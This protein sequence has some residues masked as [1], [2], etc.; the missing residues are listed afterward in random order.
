MQLSFIACFFLLF[1]LYLLLFT[2]YFLLFTFYFLLFTLYFLYAK[3]FRLV[4][5]DGGDRIKVNASIGT[6]C[7]RMHRA[8]STS[9][10]VPADLIHRIILCIHLDLKTNTILYPGK[11]F[12]F[13]SFNGTSRGTATQSLPIRRPVGSTS[14]LET[15]RN[16]NLIFMLIRLSLLVYVF[17][18]EIIRDTYNNC[19]H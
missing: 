7:T 4:I 8:R 18:S 16:V 15:L 5:Q 1:T 12:D 10:S 3:H 2:L 9:E 17:H 6:G 14:T 13:Y 11:G 19:I